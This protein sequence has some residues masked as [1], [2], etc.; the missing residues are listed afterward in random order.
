MPE[1]RVPG[2]RRG[3]RRGARAG[4]DAEG[5]CGHLRDGGSEDQLSAD[6]RKILLTRALRTFAYGYLGVVLG[7]YLDQ[8]GLDPFLIGIVLTS[9]VVGSAVM[10]VVWSLL[11]DRVGRRRTVAIMAGLM[12]AGGLLFALTDQFALLLV[13]AFTGTI[14]VTSSEFGVFQTVEQAILPQTAPSERRTWIFSIYNFTANIAQAVGSL[15]AAS[16]GVFA[17]LGLSGPDAYRPLFVL[18]ALIGLA[19]L[20]IFASLSERVELAPVEGERRLFGIHRSRGMVARL[21]A[22]FAFDSFAGGFVV[23]SVVA[24]WFYLRWGFEPGALAVLF[25]AVNVLSGLSLLVAGWLAGRIGLLN[26][27][28]F[29]HLPSNVLL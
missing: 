26:T 12:T 20:A 14:S 23:Y 5:G 21:S 15:F 13:G 10:T 17:G 7:A 19:N 25:F 3:A 28:V 9:A 18:Y 29:T 6:G 8:L 2:R 24:Y 27:M 22:L 4:E 1:R 16:V 11:A